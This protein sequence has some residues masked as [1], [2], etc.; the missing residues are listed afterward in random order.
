[1]A[2][3]NEIKAE[4]TASDTAVEKLRIELVDLCLSQIDE[5]RQKRAKNPEMIFNSLVNIYNAI[6]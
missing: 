6:K 3:E 2:K 5:I 4:K 1:M